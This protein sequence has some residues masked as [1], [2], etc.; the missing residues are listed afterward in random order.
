LEEW[1]DKRKLRFKDE[2]NTLEH[3]SKFKNPY[4]VP[5]IDY[6]TSDDGLY[7]YVM[8]IGKTIGIKSIHDLNYY[9]RDI[10][11]NNIL[12]VEDEIKLADFGLV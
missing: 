12:I 8:P 6:N 1:T 3:L 7:W 5:L 9:H 4:V 2:I 11:P 10:K